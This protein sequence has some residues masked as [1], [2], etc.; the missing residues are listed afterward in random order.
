MVKKQTITSGIPP[1]TESDRG[2]AKKVQIRKSYWTSTWYP[3][4][5]GPKTGKA[6]KMV[7]L[8]H[9]VNLNKSK[10]FYNES[11]QLNDLVSNLENSFNQISFCKN[12][13]GHEFASEYYSSQFEGH[14]E[15]F[16]FTKPR[17]WERYADNY[18]GVCLAFS[19]KKILALNEIKHKLIYKDV[20]YLKYSE[21]SCRKVDYISGNYLLDVGYDK[22]KEDIEKIAESSFFLQAY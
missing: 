1:I 6:T 19:K 4:N 21:L 3:E 16:G 14:E 22:Y 8:Q 20:E 12:Y 5:Q 10:D 15:I 7:R 2:Y 13:I 9:Y 17:M 11:N 18:S